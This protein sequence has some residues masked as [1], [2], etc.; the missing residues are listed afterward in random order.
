[1][2]IEYWYRAKDNTLDLQDQSMTLD[3]ETGVCMTFDHMGRRLHRSELKP[4]FLKSW[5]HEHE[6][7]FRFKY[8]IK[9]D[10]DL[11]MDEGL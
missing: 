3:M 6:H 5:S 2:A 9:R 7:V 4:A 8:W 1:M 11:T 10:P